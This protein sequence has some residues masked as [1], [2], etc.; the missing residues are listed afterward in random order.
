M[1]ITESCKERILKVESVVLQEF[2][3][4]KEDFIKK[5]KNISPENSAILDV[6]IYFLHDFE[7]MSYATICA[8]YGKKSQSTMQRKRQ[9]VLDLDPHLEDEYILLQKIEQIK[10]KYINT[11]LYGKA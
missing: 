1:T 3:T 4:L 8:F 10:K 9:R 5:G 2:N 7:K 6:V 11:I